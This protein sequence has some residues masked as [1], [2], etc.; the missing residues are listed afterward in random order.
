M[1]K[2]TLSLV[3]IFLSFL[4]AAQ[5]DF[6]VS[7]TGN[8]A[9]NGSF[10]TPWKTFQYACNN[11]TPGSTVYFFSGSYAGSV[12]MNVSGTAGNYITFTNY[13][14]NTVTIDGG[15]TNTQI[16][17]LNISGAAYIRIIGLNFT[18]AM[19]NFSKG[20]VIRN[21][22]HDID[23]INNKISNINF[24]TNPNATV[25][26]SKN[27]NPLLVY[28]EN[29]TTSCSNINI[30]KNEI[31]SCR[32]G[33]SEALTLNGNVD[34]FVVDSNVIYNITNIGI[35]I[36]GG[37]GVCSNTAKD[38][39]RNGIVKSNT[40]YNCVSGVAVA[41]GIYADGAQNIIIQNNKV[42]NCG[43][44]FEVGCENAGKT[45]TNITVRDNIAYENIE[46]GIGIGG[47]NYPLTGKV[48]NC[49]I[50]NNTCCNNVTG[51]NGDGELL[52]EY[53]EDCTIENNIFNA[54]NTLKRM[55]VTRLNSIG[56]T[57]NYNLYYHSAGQA[58][59]TYDYNGTVYTGF[60]S[61]QTGTAKDVQ[62]VFALPGFVNGATAN[63]NLLCNSN[64]INAGNPAFITGVNETDYYGGS[65]L[66]NG[67]VDAG[68]VETNFQNNSCSTILQCIVYLQG[69]TDT[70]AGEM[71]PV[72]MNQGI[73]N[74]SNFTDSV[75][76]ELHHPV[77]FSLI[78]S[79]KA[80][81]LKNG[82]V[83]LSYPAV[84]GNYYL[85]VKHRNSL[86]TWSSAAVSF[87]AGLITAYNFTTASNKAYG[88]NMIET[89]PGIWAIYTGDINN[90]GN[91]DIGDFA[92]WETAYDQLASGYISSDLNGDGNTDISDYIIW[93]TNYYELIAADYPF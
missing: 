78:Q 45:A 24:S 47:Y 4:S 67:K 87:T 5:T 58:T 1:S 73:G 48:T 40:V 7:T 25:T 85:A 76:I 15:S 28:G 42:Y 39:A 83:Q 80:V 17:L 79:E 93:E 57:I 13:P 84:S 46:A 31:Y 26:A 2:L 20:I 60:S 52:V 19:G 63:F 91:I 41:A 14:G 18:N 43:R 77:T 75:T 37:Y 66:L 82:L 6:Y 3:C 16:E 61:Y 64:A 21:G 68:A 10:A 92:I 35:D 59:S 90:D 49:S 44:G 22:A 32:T 30:T 86:Q 74:N 9:S 11:A 33:Y 56:L 50:L 72:L 29:S 53:T 51:N 36:A 81:L 62:S 38:A 27:T 8:N 69:Y 54:S 71:I 12:Y 89:A 88:D 65:R 55:L 34:G 23:I 70:A